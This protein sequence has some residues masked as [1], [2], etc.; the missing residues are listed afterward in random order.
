MKEM[1]Y[2]VEGVGGLTI[3]PRSKRA[4]AARRVP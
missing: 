2:V 3:S 1:D 4:K